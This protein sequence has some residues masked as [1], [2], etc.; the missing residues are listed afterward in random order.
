MYGDIQK[1]LWGF[2][3]NSC[4]LEV[5]QLQ[6]CSEIRIC[7]SWDLLRSVSQGCPCGYL[8]DPKQPCTC[9]ERDIARYKKKVSGPIIDRIDLHVDVPVVDIEALSQN[10]HGAES[11]KSIRGRVAH[12][13][14]TQSERFKNTD[15]HTNSEMKNK[16]I[17]K[18]C[19]LNI[20]VNKLLTQA[21]KTFNL[22]A[23]SFYKMIKV[24]RTIA[25]LNQ[26]ET[27]TT[28]HMAEALQYR[29]KMGS[30][31]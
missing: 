15:I 31:E 4:F 21:A 26:E 7:Y 2:V 20:E 30:G 8:Y 19:Q 13:R 1:N 27:I 25:D 3:C 14:S 24:A 22:S 9:T 28:L 12:A 23:R 17:K 10:T 6:K 29:P 18:F 11:S 16:H 5:C